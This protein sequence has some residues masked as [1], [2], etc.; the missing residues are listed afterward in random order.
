MSH[1][2]Q[3]ISLVRIGTKIQSSFE[4]NY[5][6]ILYIVNAHSCTFLSGNGQVDAIIIII[7]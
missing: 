3:Q 4:F 6:L 5:L 1:L 2:K 7:L